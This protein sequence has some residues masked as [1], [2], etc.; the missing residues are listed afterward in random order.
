MVTAWSWYLAVQLFLSQFTCNGTGENYFT[1]LS[2]LNLPFWLIAVGPS[3]GCQVH[4]SSIR[5]R[6][7]GRGVFLLNFSL[8]YL[9]FSFVGFKTVNPTGLFDSSHL[10]LVWGSHAPLYAALS[11][12]FADLISVKCWIKPQEQTLSALTERSDVQ[13][14]TNLPERKAALCLVQGLIH[15]T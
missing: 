15:S 9:H 4:S 12:V 11:I 8:S 10:Q 3:S 1:G 5:W 6:P 14:M 2:N 7:T 13:C